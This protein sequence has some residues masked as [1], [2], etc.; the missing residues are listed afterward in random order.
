M[1]LS[2]NIRPQ[3]IPSLATIAFSSLVCSLLLGWMQASSAQAS[4]QPIAQTS[5]PTSQ[6]TV[7][8]PAP[9]EVMTALTQIDAAANRQDVQGVMQFFSR[10][11]THADGLTRN[12]LEEA[13]RSFWSHYSQLNYQTAL[14]SW[15]R[16]GTAI[17]TETTT[18]I[19]G[20]QLLSGRELKLNAMIKSRHRFENGQI[21]HQEVLS[22]QSQLSGGEHP[23]TVE[24]VLPEQVVIG[25][26]FN[27]DAIVQEPLGERL[28][29]GA[30][31]EEPVQASTYLNPAAGDLELLSS[32]GL[33]K[34]GRAPALPDDRWIS[35]VIIREDGIVAET[36]RLRVVG[37]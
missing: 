34:T 26:N 7:T 17:V 19:T 4:A 9:T 23:P 3:Q 31:I 8:E 28:I 25:R 1:T 18:T 6:P 13:L 32:G 14:D 11:F 22:E 37:Q 2:M 5:A 29:L 33:F 12:S 10:N 27:F 21:V 36:R 35:A 16:E 30:A 15:T 24:V 20:T